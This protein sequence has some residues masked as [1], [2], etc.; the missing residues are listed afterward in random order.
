MFQYDVRA[1]LIRICEQCHTEFVYIK[2]TELFCS[3]QCK[4]QY[5]YDSRKNPYSITDLTEHRFIEQPNSYGEYYVDPDILAQAEFYADCAYEANG[6]YTAYIQED[7]DDLH[8][9]LRSEYA[10]S[11][12]RYERRAQAKHSGKEY[13]YAKS[14]KNY[15]RKKKGLPKLSSVRYHN[16]TDKMERYHKEKR[17]DLPKLV[18]VT[19]VDAE[20]EDQGFFTMSPSRTKSGKLISEVLDYAKRKKSVGST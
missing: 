19:E 12:A 20:V 16:W 11:E 15:H 3:K 9:L 18:K 14:M 13:W 10:L 7:T 5:E 8:M 2:K 1:E 4:R 17:G 6:G